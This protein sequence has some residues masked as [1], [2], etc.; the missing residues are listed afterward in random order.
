MKRRSGIARWRMVFATAGV[1]LLVPLAGAKGGDGADEVSLEEKKVEAPRF[2]ITDT[3]PRYFN[4]SIEFRDVEAKMWPAYFLARGA[5]QEGHLYPDE[6]QPRGSFV[7]KSHEMALCQGA[8]DK[9]IMGELVNREE[10]T[11]A[12]GEKQVVPV[13]PVLVL[14]VSSFSPVKE[15]EVAPPAKGKRKYYEVEALLDISGKKVPLK[16][17]MTMS[18]NMDI[19]PIERK[20]ALMSARVRL[21]FEVMGLDLG[22]RVNADKKVRITVHTE[23]FPKGATAADQKK[24][25]EK[26]EKL[27]VDPDDVFKP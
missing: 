22:L 12:R 26:I 24:T 16:G 10:I 1:G 6:K 21:D 9:R 13:P 27:M 18:R 8:Q 3:N 17:R 23:A 15:E 14:T 4:T 20:M 5:N 25:E 7:L 11:D 2:E 19:D